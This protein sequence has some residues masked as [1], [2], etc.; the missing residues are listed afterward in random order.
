[1]NDKWWLWIDNQREEKR[2]RIMKALQKRL[3]V[4]YEKSR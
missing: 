3:N 1:M 2:A 4:L